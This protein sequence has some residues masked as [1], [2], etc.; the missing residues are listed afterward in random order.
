MKHLYNFIAVACFAFLLEACDHNTPADETG[1]SVMCL[2]VVKFSAPEFSDYVVVE[3]DYR[4]DYED[5]CLLRPDN[6]SFIDL[7]IGSS[8][9]IA[10]PQGYYV[11]DWKWSQLIYPPTTFLIDVKWNELK[12]RRQKW[13]YP[14]IYITSK[15]LK[16]WGCIPCSSIDYYLNIKTNPNEYKKPYWMDFGPYPQ[17]FKHPEYVLNIYMNEVRR[18][19]SLQNV[20][21]ERLSRIIE[22]GHLEKVSPK[23]YWS[24]Y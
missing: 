20:S 4:G 17:S 3:K 21:I 16:V 1:E 6:V 19:D 24:K 18:E 15:F 9:Y 14:P 23:V 8:P 11:V 22:E 5:S 2:N 10:L 7:C 12:D 13:E